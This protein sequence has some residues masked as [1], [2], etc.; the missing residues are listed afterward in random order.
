MG[1]VKL[2]EFRRFVRKVLSE[3]EIKSNPKLTGRTAYEPT[4]K[5]LYVEWDDG[6]QIV[7]AIYNVTQ[8]DDK[9]TPWFDYNNDNKPDSNPATLV[10]EKT[11]SGFPE[12]INIV[13]AASAIAAA[14]A[15]KLKNPNTD[16][17]S[18]SKLSGRMAT[19]ELVTSVGNQKLEK[20]AGGIEK[21]RPDFYKR[22]KEMRVAAKSGAK[23]APPAGATPAETPAPTAGGGGGGSR[24]GAS[25]SP[26]KSAVR[27]KKGE[28]GFTLRFNN[29]SRGP[30]T[31]LAYLLS[32][33]DAQGLGM[34]EG[35]M[36]MGPK[37][38]GSSAAFIG[39][40]KTQA[41]AQ[42][43]I[44]NIFADDKI[45]AAAKAYQNMSYIFL[46]Y[47]RGSVDNVE[48]INPSKVAATSL[49]KLYSEAT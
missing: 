28:Y 18:V 11:I 19:P 17:D 29:T 45:S 12:G 26:I 49:S 3:G 40:I 36:V 42:V 43:D 41:G 37:D 35:K 1:K 16:I 44:K 2:S 20:A 24:T 47:Y 8:V 33:N 4:S 21:A 31:I 38:P 23:A 34:P 30:I 48:D 13:T 5:K 7:V 32:T 27:V 14:K 25:G 15:Y 39:G 10:Y 46:R 6:D 22:K 9:E